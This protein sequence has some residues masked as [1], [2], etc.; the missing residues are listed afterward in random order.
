VQNG[1]NSGLSLNQILIRKISGVQYVHIEY[2]SFNPYV[3][4]I[5]LFYVGGLKFLKKT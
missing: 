2:V 1:S 4:I 5:Y 3:T